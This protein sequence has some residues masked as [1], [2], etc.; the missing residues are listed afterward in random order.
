MRPSVFSRRAHWESR[1]HNTTRIGEGHALGG[2]GAAGAG[3]QDLAAVRTTR[4]AAAERRRQV[5]L[6][7]VRCPSGFNGVACHVST[8]ETN[9][10]IVLNPH[11]HKTKR[12]K[13]MPEGERRLG[14][15]GGAGPE[16]L[17]SKVRYAWARP[18]R[19]RTCLHPPTHP[20]NHLHRRHP[21]DAP[22][23]RHCLGRRPSESKSAARRS[24]GP[25]TRSAAGR[26]RSRSVA[27]VSW[28]LFLVL[29]C[30][31]GGGGEQPGWVFVR[32]CGRRMGPLF[33]SPYHHHHSFPFYH[34]YHPST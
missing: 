25:W 17:S 19:T 6:L 28:V 26:L 27:T 34:T 15:A 9:T 22:P 24:A 33:I 7:Y 8:H 29:S 10:N 31:G 21:S 16:P 11:T 30:V 20:I 3:G 4:A 12:G 23:S 13:V 18:S 5:S 14:G 2:G 32:S 1:K